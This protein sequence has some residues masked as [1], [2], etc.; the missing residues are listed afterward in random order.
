MI[1]ASQFKRDMRHMRQHP[2]FTTMILGLFALAVIGGIMLGLTGCSSVP[3]SEV[4]PVPVWVNMFYW[5]YKY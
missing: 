1:D 3:Q 5:G 2:I 4:K